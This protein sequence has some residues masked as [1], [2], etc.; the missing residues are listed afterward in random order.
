M[1]DFSLIVDKILQILISGIV[2]DKSE[3]D[4]MFLDDI[5]DL[6]ILI[7]EVEWLLI[8]RVILWP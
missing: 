1:Q 7:L 5:P 6:P 8:H 4:A 2:L 3:L